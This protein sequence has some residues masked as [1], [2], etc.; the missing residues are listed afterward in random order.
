MRF[1]S[2]FPFLLLPASVS[3]AQSADTTFFRGTVVYTAGSRADSGSP[4][5]AL[6]QA[7]APVTQRVIFGSRG[8]IRLTED[9]GAYTDVI[10]DLPNDRHYRLNREDSTAQKLVRTDYEEYFPPTVLEPIDGTEIISGHR[11]R[12][13]R[14]V[15]SQF[16]RRGAAAYLWVADD[17]RLVRERGDY[18]HGESG[19]RALFPLPM[20]LWVA[21]GT[22]MKAEITEQ[23]V[24]VT[25]TAELQ[26]GEPADE[27]FAIPAGYRVE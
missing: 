26:P 7:F 17:V 3:A 10:I 20:V 21:E 8:R 9:D 16:V 12:K 19:F 24:T 23:E 13:Y 11:A 25:Y 27:I 2:I 22:V 18:N 6:F 1:L 14:V 15:S 4:E 5:N